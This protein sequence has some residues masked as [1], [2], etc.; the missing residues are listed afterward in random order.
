MET[1]T[2]IAGSKGIILVDGSWDQMHKAGAGMVGYNG[3]NH[4]VIANYWGFNTGDP[5]M[6][7]VITMQKAVRWI[8]SHR[9]SL[10]IQ[11]WVMVSDCATLV[12]LL[13]TQTID[14]IPS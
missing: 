2:G 6:A 8:Q 1:T 11:S 12:K 3:R 14:G 13:Q 9:K 7:E 5:F 4:S 10:G